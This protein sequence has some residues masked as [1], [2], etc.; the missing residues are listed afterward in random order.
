[1]S[2]W[3]WALIAFWCLVIALWLAGDWVFGWLL[4]NFE[5]DDSTPDDRINDNLE[6]RRDD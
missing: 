1:M 6:D 2:G 3:A 5:L 4:D